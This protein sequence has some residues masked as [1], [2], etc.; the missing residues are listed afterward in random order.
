MDRATETVRYAS[1]RGRGVLLASVLGSS[2]A[3]LDSTAVN[4]ALHVLG[5]ELGAGLAGLQWAVDAYLL[6]LG[7]LVLTGGALGDVFGQRRVFEE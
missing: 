7:A 2:M 5:R 3:F 4:V 6:T 1:G